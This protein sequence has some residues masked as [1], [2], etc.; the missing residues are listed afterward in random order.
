MPQNLPVTATAVAA[1]TT[2][3]TGKSAATAATTGST[4]TAATTGSTATEST[5][6]STA[7]E[8][9]TGSAT[10]ESTTG[11]TTAVAASHAAAKTTGSNASVSA[12]HTT[13]VSASHTAC[14]TARSAGIS[15]AAYI[16]TAIAVPAAISVAAVAVTPAPAVPRSDANERAAVEPL[17]TVIAIRR[18]G[19]GVIIVV[20]PITDRGAVGIRG[21]SDCGANA[22][23]LIH[24]SVCRYR[25]RQSRSIAIKTRRIFRI[26]PPCAALSCPVPF[27]PDLGPGVD[28]R[29]QH[30]P[31]LGIS[32]RP[33]SDY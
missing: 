22:N 13:G 4:A 11:S 5:T 29:L 16:A 33:A 6:G 14:I 17:R 2:T 8:S 32:S 23:T 25:E 15:P 24:L 31:A 21:V 9:T 18:A 26:N 12:C 7:A 28:L 10:T 27:I 30:L 3:A 19:V 20:A 1:T